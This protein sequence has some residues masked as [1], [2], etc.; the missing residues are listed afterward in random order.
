[1]P[2]L[3]DVDVFSGGWELFGLGHFGLRQLVSKLG[4]S[5]SYGGER[6][7]TRPDGLGIGSQALA[8]P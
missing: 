3:V 4:A 8:A 5:P 6:R 1:M 7:K 2:G